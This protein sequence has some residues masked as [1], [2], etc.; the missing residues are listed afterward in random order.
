MAS[1]NRRDYPRKLLVEGETDKRVIPYLM[2]ANGVMWPDPPASPVFIEPYGSVDEIL[3]PEVISLEIGASGLDV[4]GVVVD[5]N[6]DAASTVGPMSRRGVAVSFPICRTRFPP[7]VW[8]VVHSGGPRFGVWIMP[9]NR[10]TGM[11][12]D[13][14][15][16][17]IPGD[18]RGLF[19]LAAS[20]VADAKRRGAPFRDVH[21]RKAEIHTWLAWQDPPDLRLHEALDHTVLH[22]ARA[23]SQ[24]FV[25]WFRR[26]FGV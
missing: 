26:L 5:A 2:E 14:L 8:S 10:L 17:L 1:R 6:G 16:R 21:V 19:E 13:F 20:S 9:D 23:E 11:L 18:S 25:N 22:P 15:V 12:E 4:L 3:K 7:L 24:P